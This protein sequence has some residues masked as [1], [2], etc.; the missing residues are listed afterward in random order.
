MNETLS[1]WGWVCIV[2]D[3]A[4]L[5]VGLLVCGLWFVV[6]GL[7]FVGLLVGLVEAVQL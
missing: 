1:V 4:L 2:V 6:C 3:C 7:W 5:I